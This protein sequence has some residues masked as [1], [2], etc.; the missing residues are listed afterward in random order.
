MQKENREK[1]LCG[2]AVQKLQGKDTH[3]SSRKDSIRQTVLADHAASMAI[4]NALTP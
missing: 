1:A 2:F 4:L 3:M